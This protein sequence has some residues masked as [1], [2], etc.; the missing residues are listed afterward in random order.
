M[1]G[2]TFGQVMVRAQGV[3]T[4]SLGAALANGV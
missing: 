4:A 1:V 3:E 2:L